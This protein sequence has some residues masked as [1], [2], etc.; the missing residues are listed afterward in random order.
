M[1]K[2]YFTYILI[3]FLALIAWQGHEIWSNHS[4]FIS[5]SNPSV[6]FLGDALTGKSYIVHELN[7]STPSKKCSDGAECSKKGLDRRDYTPNNSEFTYQLVDFPG[8]GRG[9]DYDWLKRTMDFIDTILH[10]KVGLIVYTIFLDKN[11]RINPFDLDMILFFKSYLFKEGIEM[12]DRMIFVFTRYDARSSE[13]YEEH[14]SLVKQS[15]ADTLF[16]F[17]ENKKSLL[18]L[19]K[20]KIL[21][22]RNKTEFKEEL[23]GILRQIGDV[24]FKVNTFD[25]E[26]RKEFV[27]EYH[28]YSRLI[29]QIQKEKL[30]KAINKTESSIEEYEKK[31]EET[32]EKI[33]MLKVTLKEKERLW[34]KMILYK[35]SFFYYLIALGMIYLLPRVFSFTTFMNYIKNNLSKKAQIQGKVI[36]DSTQ[37]T[38]TSM[39]DKM[40]KINLKSEP[41]KMIIIKNSKKPKSKRGNRNAMITRAI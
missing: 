7:S 5:D 38:L 4:L 16:A 22:Y 25:E 21:F 29:D 27:V 9:D 18:G 39:N 33:E 34:Y 14:H 23:D 15:W 17:H 30:K 3:P 26:K 20:C 1:K 12:S 8:F 6:L 40:P 24:S 31:L 2:F 13:V 11:L 36:K 19:D 35:D 28:E 10:H 41:K 32:K 37:H